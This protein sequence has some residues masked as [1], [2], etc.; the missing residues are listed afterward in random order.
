MTRFDR[1]NEILVWLFYGRIWVQS[2][3]KSLI[4]G[5]EAIMTTAMTE[6]NRSLLGC[7]LTNG[8]SALLNAVTITAVRLV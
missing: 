3:C 4:S 7:K 2:R 8:L 6:E 5:N 1:C